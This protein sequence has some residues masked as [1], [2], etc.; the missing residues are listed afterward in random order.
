MLIRRFNCH[1]PREFE[2][3]ARQLARCDK[4]CEGAASHTIV[5]L[6]EDRVGMSGRESSSYHGWSK[7]RLRQ[8]I[9][10]LVDSSV[11]SSK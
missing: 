4:L 11:G 3:L 1:V 7:L 5:Q 6:P 8:A 10:P 2:R 9:H